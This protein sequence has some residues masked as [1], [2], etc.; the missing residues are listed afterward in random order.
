[1]GGFNI[2]PQDTAALLDIIY[3]L[4]SRV[5]RF[6]ASTRDTREM[7]WRVSEMMGQR[8]A[9]EARIQAYVNNRSRYPIQIP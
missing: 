4:L 8:G 3:S 2:Q 5:Q 1:M 9:K 7:E 6:T